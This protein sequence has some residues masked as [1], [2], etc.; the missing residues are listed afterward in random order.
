M[1]CSLY[2]CNSLIQ[3]QEVSAFVTS[4]GLE[5]YLCLCYQYRLM[6]LSGLCYNSLVS[7]N[8]QKKQYHTFPGF[9]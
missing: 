4:K 7:G 2:S 5:A 1:L 9:T 6:Q 8:V 3:L